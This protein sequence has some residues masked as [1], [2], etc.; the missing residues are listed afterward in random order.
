MDKQTFIS[1]KIAKLIAEGRPREQAIAIAINM[2]KEKYQEGGTFSPTM[3]FEEER[4]SMAPQK[5]IFKIQKVITSDY[6]DNNQLPPG[7]YQ[8]VFYTD[9]N[10][11]KIEN[12]DFEYLDSSGYKGLQNMSNYKIYI[13]SLRQPMNNN[14]LV[15][16]QEGGWY[17]NINPF[18][19]TAQQN[20]PLNEGQYIDPTN[21]T[22]EGYIPDAEMKQRMAQNA[23]T[24]S[25]INPNTG[26]DNYDENGN[27]INE[28]LRYNDYTRY[29]LINPFSGGFGL[30]Q[31]LA[32]AGKSF[33]EGKTE[34][35]IMGSA[36]SLLK[37]A[38]GFLGA[39]GAG[40]Q[41]KLL[42]QSRKDKLYNTAPNYSYLQEGGELLHYM[43][44]GGE[45]TNADLL[46][47]QFITDSDK[48]NV[49][50]EH[51]EQVKDGEDG[52]V[53]KA[54]GEKH[55]S[56]GIDT[57]LPNGSK[58][59]SDFTKIGAENAKKF[60]EKYDIKVKATDT[61]AKVMDKINKKI[62]VTDLI[63]EEKK[64]LEKVDKSL[65][66]ED[67]ST[68]EINLDFLSKE[69]KEIQ[70]KKL[71]LQEQQSQI[72]EDI[73]EAQEAIPKKGDGKELVKQEGGSVFSE[74]V[75][76]LAKKHNIPEERLAE[77][78]KMQE[79][80][81]IQNQQEEMVEGTQS[82]P[83]EEQGEITPE[84]I[85]Q[86]YAQISGVDP[87]EIVA[88]LQQ[89]PPE[90][91]QQA[92]QQMAA[93]L[94]QGGQEQPIVQEGGR[95]GSAY[96]NP[97]LY[98]K[99]SQVDPLAEGYGELLKQNPEGVIKEI[100]KL[101]PE[102][103]QK[104]F[105]GNKLKKG[106]SAFDFQKAIGDK[107]DSILKDYE[108]LYGKNSEQYN[109]ILDKIKQD[110]FVSTDLQDSN[111]RARDNKL[112]NYTVTRPNYA[113]N[114]IPKEELDKLNKEGINT[115]FELK[116]KNLEL[117]KKYVADKKLNSDF[118]LGA[119]QS[120][121]ATPATE[122]P[123]TTQPTDV[124][125]R[126]VVKNILP[127]IFMPFRS[128]PSAVIAPYL[129]QVALGRDEAQKG[130]VENSLVA[131]ASAVQNAYAQTQDLPPALRAVALS[132]F[133]GKQQAADTTA[134]ANQEIA[135]RADANRARLFNIGQSD[136]EQ[137]L[138][139]QLKKQY[140]REAF[141]NMNNSENAWNKYYGQ[142]DADRKYANDFIERRNIW[143]AN[144]DNY[145]VTGSGVDFVNS[146]RPSIDR[147]DPKIQQLFDNAKTPEERNKL[148]AQ[149][150]SMYKR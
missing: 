40:K 47:G 27:V 12:Q 55:V 141:M 112:G 16:K 87:Q 138:N 147:P 149:L 83:Q 113:L 22:Q 108:T 53:R 119:T 126:N 60:K 70:D 99:Q 146:W 67:E 25:Y 100:K 26:Q 69:V 98:I 64:Y 128:T 28:N 45:V 145:Q 74:E 137:L 54:V 136:K 109:N 135:D 139:E 114:V 42:E 73:F 31:S 123:D 93:S 118:W 111:I 124:V 58:V 5:K 52:M 86:A 77:L 121:E 75:M 59:L 144:L 134:I 110:T 72:F 91:Q 57:N 17:N 19:T 117:Y 51:G 76:A 120:P 103:Y 66:I 102:I 39:Y 21:M 65:K 3:T 20:Y 11:A 8:K 82:N 38:R 84:Q 36:L 81:D 97:N 68:K 7:E 92:L 13:D 78:M 71:A 80:G 125:D 41:N 96:E 104:M 116:T 142:L 130:S 1:N 29:N 56:G 14:Q 10:R 15:M 129:Q 90:Q 105:D 9:P 37:G 88:Q 95:I 101:H 44:K 46:T 30:D 115:A 127:D 107:Y 18:F 4:A 34:Q 131:N 32:Y 2:A 106:I 122:T 89:L 61:F 6:K 143:N 50:L 49:N 150:I 23:G 43:Q 62:G 148:Q 48:P 33:G 35:G 85:I 94:Q 140:E 24:N 79:G 63:E 133:L 132:D